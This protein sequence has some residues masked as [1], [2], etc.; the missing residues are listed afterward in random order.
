MRLP[1]LAAAT[2]FGLTYVI[3]PVALGMDVN[4]YEQLVRLS[5]SRDPNT[6]SMARTGVDAYFAG[7]AQTIQLA[8]T[9][10]QAFQVGKRRYFA[11]RLRFG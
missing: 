8:Q 5:E 3:S 2:F 10:S 6:A 7:I 11:S 9:G 4:D 1:T